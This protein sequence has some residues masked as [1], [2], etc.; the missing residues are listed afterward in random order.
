MIVKE[1]TAGHKSVEYSREG[2]KP[3][4]LFNPRAYCNA[5]KVGAWNEY[6]EDY[7]TKIVKKKYSYKNNY[8]DILEAYLKI[9]DNQKRRI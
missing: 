6:V 3:D 4:W 7:L 5:F 1:N 2:N 8:L 9:S